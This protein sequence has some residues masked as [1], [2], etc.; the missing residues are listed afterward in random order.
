M[1]LENSCVFEQ[2]ARP[3]FPG[4]QVPSK[5]LLPGV[6]Q[7]VVRLCAKSREDVLSPCEHLTLHYQVRRRM[8]A[9]G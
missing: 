9:G 6:R 7:Q 1:L 8:G 3:N 5:P 2:A 4:T